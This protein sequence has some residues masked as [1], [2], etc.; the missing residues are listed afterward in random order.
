MRI[1]WSS[2][3]DI[4]TVEAKGDWATIKELQKVIPFHLE[5][6]KDML[7]HCK[8]RPKSA[9]VDQLAFCTRF[10]AIFLFLMVKGTRRMTYQFLTDE[11]FDNAREYSH[12]FVDRRKL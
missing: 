12:G 7:D 1:E 3:L 11:M 2:S 5:K 8:L 9:S 10:I 6:Y 4:E